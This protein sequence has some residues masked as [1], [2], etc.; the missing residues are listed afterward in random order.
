MK[1]TLNERTILGQKV[2]EFLAE[3]SKN[4]SFGEWHLEFGEDFLYDRNGLR[5]IQTSLRKYRGNS[6]TLSFSLKLDAI[7]ARDYYHSTTFDLPLTATRTSG[8]GSEVLI[9]ELPATYNFVPYPT[10]L[11]KPDNGSVP[12]A[13]LL[14]VNDDF[15]LLFANQIMLL[16]TLTQ[17][18]KRNWKTPFKALVQKPLKLAL[19]FTQIHSTADVHPTAVIEGSVIEAGARIGAH[20]VVRFSHIGKNVRLHDGAKAELSYVGDN[21]W[22]MHDLVLYRSYTEDNVFL[23][24]GPYQFSGFQQSS[25]AF[26]TIMMDYRPDNKPIRK[27]YHG[28][29]LG[30]I[31]KPGAKTL[32]GSQVAPGQIINSNSWILP[33]SPTKA[34]AAYT[35]ELST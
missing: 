35:P 26:G 14:E 19:G 12:Q 28:R 21:S 6:K 1:P 13:L 20:C 4:I 16:I 7:T 11:T 23:I 31:L 25:A 15:D 30:S 9:L 5:L 10:A 32:G 2:P 17:K 29:F 24:H 3:E 22:L 33:P 8:A 34:T 27:N 18:I